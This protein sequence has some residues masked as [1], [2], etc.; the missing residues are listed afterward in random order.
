MSC[1]W[2]KIPQTWKICWFLVCTALPLTCL[3]ALSNPSLPS[4][5]HLSSLSKRDTRNLI[6]FER[7]D[8]HLQCPLSLGIM[9]GCVFN[10]EDIPAVVWQEDPSLWQQ[11]HFRAQ[12]GKEKY[13]Q[14]F[15]GDPAPSIL[16][17]FNFW[18]PTFSL[19]YLLNFSTA[20]YCGLW[21]FYLELWAYFFT[22]VS[23]IACFYQLRVIL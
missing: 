10:R 13:A 20:I 8:Y 18:T 14:S 17:N 5:F 16:A 19:Q 9:D 6:Y 2:V 21:Q 4:G 11:H 12:E 22:W 1:A 15:W 3:L 23:N 7:C